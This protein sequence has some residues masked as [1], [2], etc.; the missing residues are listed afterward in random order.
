M[1]CLPLACQMP[2]AHRSPIAERCARR[3]GKKAEAGGIA[4]DGA[5]MV[6]A[7]ANAKVSVLTLTALEGWYCPASL[8]A[9]MQLSKCCQAGH[10]QQWHC[11]P[12]A[13][14]GTSNASTHTR[15]MQQDLAMSC[16]TPAL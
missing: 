3:V 6:Q 8:G 7:V 1:A 15:A 13:L 12:L 5:K 9:S 16:C 2:R 10:I 14:G 11:R 4:K